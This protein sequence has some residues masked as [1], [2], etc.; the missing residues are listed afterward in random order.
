MKRRTF[1]NRTLQVSSLLAASAATNALANNVLA[2]PAINRAK[3]ASKPNILIVMV[4]Q[5]REFQW[6]PDQNTLNSK[7]PNIMAL[8]NESVKFMRYYTAASMCEP[9]RAS[10]TTGLYAHQ[11]W[12]MLTQMSH[13][14][15]D[16]P[17]YGDLLIA[18]GYH[19]RWFGKW[20]L[21][22]DTSDLSPWGFSGSIQNDPTGAPA[23]GQNRDPQIAQEFVDWLPTAPTNQPWCCTVSLVNPHD[24]MWYPRYTEAIPQQS[25]PPQVFSDTPAN[26]ETPTDFVNRNKPGL[27]RS[28]QTMAQQ[29]FGTMHYSGVSYQQDWSKFLD[30]YLLLQQMVDEQV[31]NVLTALKNSAFKDNTIV[32]FFA[33]HGEYCGSHGMRGKGAGVYEEGIRVPFCVKDPTGQYAS[34]IPTER[35]QLASSVD[36][37]PFL[38]TIGS[39]GNAWRNDPTYAHLKNRLDMAAICQNANAAGRNY[40]LS[41]TDEEAYEEAPSTGWNDNPPNHV[42][43]YRTANA[44]IA[45]YNYW[46]TNSAELDLTGQQN[47]LYDY[48]TDTG[49]KE[50]DNI[51]TSNT[52]L[53]DQ[54]NSELQTAI[55]GE[56]RE[57]L[58]TAL[59]NAQTAAWFQYLKD[60]G[61]TIYNTNLPLIT[62]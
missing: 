4:D 27:Q 43:G 13:L 14:H 52:T 53:F 3:A 30:L 23:Q 1:L 50:L 19:T 10:L 57:P 33:D 17:T 11:H 21:S 38:L 45:S 25:N 42:I 26:F 28:S 12:C 56:L 5:M 36:L 49:V 20:H 2:F 34:A 58:P 31:G 15:P 39:G 22:A 54:L 24:I 48:A 44:K 47:E 8:R 41:T 18:Q 62:N 59:R 32:I 35:N 29:Q 37:A 60:T 46:K 7:L 16:F 51:A 61:G 40:V 9:A 55:S 6:F